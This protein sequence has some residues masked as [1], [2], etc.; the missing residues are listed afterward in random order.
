MRDLRQVTA[1]FIALG[2]SLAAM[3]L[4]A[5][6][7]TIKDCEKIEAADAYNQ[8]LASFGPVAHEH[9]LGAVPAGADRLSYGYRHRSRHEAIIERHGRRKRMQLSVEPGGTD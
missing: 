2:F 1:I 7:A 3:P 8:C 5:K 6:P 9:E 4:Q